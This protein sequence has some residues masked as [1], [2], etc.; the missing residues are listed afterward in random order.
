VNLGVGLTHRSSS[1]EH[2]CGQEGIPWSVVQF[3]EPMI[4]DGYAAI[5]LTAPPDREQSAALEQYVRGGGAILA[6]APYAAGFCGSHFRHEHVDYLLPGGRITDVGVVDLEL[7]CA[8]PVEANA[9]ITST[10]SPALFIGPLW[11]GYCG[12][13]PFD[14]P[15]VLHDTRARTRQF[16]AHRERLPFE[17]VSAVAK[18][19]A[20]YVVGRLLEVLFASRGLPLVRKARFPDGAKTM[21]VFRVDSDGGSRDEVEHLHHLAQR[22]ETPISW[23]LDVRSH[24]TWLDAFRKVEGDEVGLHCYDHTVFPDYTRNLDNI[25]RAISVLSTAGIDVEGFAAPQGRWNEQLAA[26]VDD[27]G[28]LYSS[29][30]SYMYDG[31]PIV[32]ETGARRFAAMQVPVHPICTGSLKRVGYSEPQ[33]SQYFEMVIDHKVRR[34]EPLVFY[35]HPKDT[36]PRAVEHLLGTLQSHGPRTTMG[37]FARWWELREGVSFTVTSAQNA[38]IQIH[39]GGV[40]M[41]GVLRFE[42]LRPDGSKTI[43]AP[44]QQIDLAQC[45]WESPTRVALSADRLRRSRMFDLRT[46]IADIYTHVT[47]WSR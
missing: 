34:G 2:W 1:W 32:P 24:E 9:L 41:P 22:F 47:G 7:G 40:K 45:R 8:I 33:M 6:Y 21:V 27:C 20:L 42:I 29:E 46:T 3:G 14:L 16:P 43:T 11:G 35:H 4:V 44:D 10:G 37:R 5:V 39:A 23:F 19:E 13:L 28:F 25:Q 17:R 12:L 38:G 31:W 30:F 26:A 36:F 18:G 15:D